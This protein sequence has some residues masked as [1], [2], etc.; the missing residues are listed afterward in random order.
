MSIKIERAIL[1]ALDPAAGTA[2]LSEEP[3]N[4]DE[5]VREFLETHFIKCL[6]SDEAQKAVLRE[7][8][9][10]GQR[11]RGLGSGDQITAEA[12]V[13]ESRAVAERIF[14]I[15]GANPDIPRGDLICML[16]KESGSGRTY[17]AALKMNYYDGFAHYYM[18]GNLSIVGQRVL[19]PGIGRKLEE[20]F[21]VDLETLET[22]VIEKKYLMM[23]ESRS[24]YISEQVLG[25]TVEV[26]ERSKLMAVKK[27]V[28]KANKEV[29]GDRKVVEQELM[30]R[31]HG[32][33]M[34]EDEPTVGEMCREVLR[35]YPQVRPMVEEDIMSNHIELGDSVLVQ[36]RTMKR[37]E[38]QSVKTPNGI[39][40]KIPA[41][42]F[43]DPN[44][45]EFIQNP[46]GTIS[47]LVK[48]IVL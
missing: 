12:F 27:A 11:M 45:V 2:V 21:I 43:S 29:L 30:S 32:Y 47:L 39:E 44:S 16:C 35:D 37:F 41:D 36:P 17:F 8:G 34:D 31:I 18:N 3:M 23:D 9:S 10:F 6:E 33:L 19:L 38:K 4:I 14:S 7:E 46:D 1:H 20:A 13:A 25:C 15:L 28:Q 48:N 22:Q 42:L 26:S 40:V 5:E 24:A